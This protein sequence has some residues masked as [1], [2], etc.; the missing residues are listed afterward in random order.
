[1]ASKV[2]GWQ[3]FFVKD[4]KVNILNFAGYVG[5][6]VSINLHHYRTNATNK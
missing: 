4:Q 3:T 1:M 5:S 2:R 6:V